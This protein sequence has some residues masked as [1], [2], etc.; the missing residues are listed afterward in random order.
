MLVLAKAMLTMM[1]SFLLAIICGLI[2]I[3]L[4]K[5]NNTKQTVS[6]FLSKK[7]LEKE[8][9]PT[10]GGFIFII[11]TLIT[12]FILLITKKIDYSNNLLIILFVFVGYALIGFIDD[13]LIIKRKNNKGLSEFK[14]LTLQLIIALVFFFIFL[15]SG[16]NPE[17][18][19]HTLNI[20]LQLKWLYGLFILFVL[21][22]SSNAVNITDGLDGLAGGLSLISFLALGLI[23]WNSTWVN[24]SQDI[25]I[26]CFILVGSLLGFLFFNTYPAKVF[27]G[28]TGSLS[29]GATMAS[30]A[31]LTN[32]E[33]TFIIIATVFIVETL[34]VII[35]TLS[36]MLYGKKVFLMTPLHH[37][38]EKLGWLERDIVKTFWVIGILFAMSGVIFAVWI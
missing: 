9:T 10:M 14:K 20:R 36:I 34:T 23:S 2:L 3:P 16:H 18:Y 32:H 5:K 22:A 4:F 26:F 21:V 1:A 30:I 17:L 19:V 27:M 29:L 6:K 7:H 12:I 25:A 35:Q 11:P 8:G 33:I 13:Y 31:I 24:G 38:F 15:K 37:H 28:D